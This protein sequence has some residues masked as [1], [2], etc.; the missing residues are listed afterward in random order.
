MPIK[1]TPIDRTE[2][3]DISLKKGREYQLSEP[4]YSFDDVVLDEMVREEINHILTMVK[5]RELLYEKWNLKSVFPVQK[6]I[7]INLYGASGT[8]KTMTAHAIANRL[9]KK[10]LLV[11]YA[12]IES[13]FVGETSK[14]L[15]ALFDFAGRSGAVLVFD[16]ADALLSKRVTSMTNATDVSV[17]QTRNVLLKLLDEFQGIV[18]FTT[19][20][21]SNYDSA[22]FRRIFAHIEF[23]L[24]DREARK[25]IWE[26]YLVDALPLDVPKQEASEL[27]SNIEGATGADISNAVLKTAVIAAD[28]DQVVKL[29]MLDS[30]LR[31]ALK[32]RQEI[33][34]GGFEITTRKVTKEYAEERL[35]GCVTNGCSESN[36]GSGSSGS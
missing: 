21:I 33:E 8:G 34:C 17:N 19:N 14:N 9:G 23:P 18:I 16:E 10:V 1:H 25:R 24:P 12:E 35:G 6:S 32:K 26:H 3:P 7:S 28:G 15:V 11:S 4:V 13:K 31:N 22:F 30:E 29:A 2:K 20:F 27:L 36:M 5:H